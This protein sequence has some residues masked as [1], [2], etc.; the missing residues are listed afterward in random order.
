LL[1]QVGTGLDLLVANALAESAGT[2][3]SPLDTSELRQVYAETPGSD[4]GARLDA[5]V[6]QVNLR[7]PL[8]ERREPGY[9][10]PLQTGHRV[11][12]GAHHA[13]VSTALSLVPPSGSRDRTARI[14]DI[15]CRLPSQSLFAADLAVRYF[16]RTY[17]LHLNQPP[18]LA[19]TYNAGRPLPSWDNLWNL[20]QYGDHVD[21]W[22]RYYN[23]CRL[24]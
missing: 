13:L 4:P 12:L 21:R 20:R 14:A 2:V 11:S 22:V 16:A 24:V 18:L 3:P 19:A 6:R 5:V 10:N 7:A 15:V 17:G 1:D 8:L 9:V 23:T